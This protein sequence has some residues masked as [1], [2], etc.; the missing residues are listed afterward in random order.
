MLQGL[1]DGAYDWVDLKRLVRTDRVATP[2]AIVRDVQQGFSFLRDL[3][4]GEAR[5]AQDPYGRERRTYD[6]LVNSVQGLGTAP[7]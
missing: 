6:F 2:E 7:H 1:A 4:E 5:L 3:T